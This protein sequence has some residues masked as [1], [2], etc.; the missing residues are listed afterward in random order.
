MDTETLNTTTNPVDNASRVRQ[1]TAEEVNAKIDR[2]MADRVRQYAE[3]SNSTIGDRIAELEREW[4][5]ERVLEANA[6]VLAFTGVLL[7]AFVNQNWLW[8]PA[9][10]L[11]FLFQ[12]AVQGWCPPLFVI[13]RLGVR[14]RDEIDCEIFALKALR[15]D[16][17]EIPER[18]EGL[19]STRA[20]EILRAIGLSG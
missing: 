13:R 16:F 19:A 9:I 7:G 20:N 3:N 15:G 17:D 14:T 6:S 18:T 1:N 12:H 11:P 4:D 8:L 5:T 10:V 2:E